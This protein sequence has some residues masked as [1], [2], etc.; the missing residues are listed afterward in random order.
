MPQNKELIIDFWYEFDKSFLSE[1]YMLKAKELLDP[2]VKLKD[3]FLSHHRKNTIEAG[4]KKEYENVKDS[5]KLLA[6][7]HFRIINEYFE[8]NNEKEQMAFELFAQG[9]LF[10]NSLD[11]DGPPRR[12]P[13]NKIHM[14]DDDMRGYLI[15]HAFIRLVVVLLYGDGTLNSKKRWLQTDR[16][17]GLAAGILA[18][19]IKSGSE[20][21]QSNDPNYNK[22]IAPTLLEELRA[23]WIHLSFQEIDDKLVQLYDERYSV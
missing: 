10:D 16:H 18:A 4:F 2:Y 12:L 22:P 5:I 7:N 23:N 13:G 20:P 3:C 8:G 14:M 21:E 19:M 9:L 17:I 11:K 6:D 15:W 1:S